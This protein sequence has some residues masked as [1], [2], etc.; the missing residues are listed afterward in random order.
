MKKIILSCI[1]ALCCV[2]A[3]AQD[4]QGSGFTIDLDVIG[5]IDAVGEFP[6][7]TGAKPSYNSG[8]SVVYTK[9]ESSFAE[10]FNL[11]WAAHWANTGGEQ[12]PFYSTPDLYRNTLLTDCTDWTDIF[13]IDFTMQGFNFRLGKDCLALGGFDYE[14]WDWDV[15]FATASSFWLNNASYQWGAQVGYTTP[16]ES[17]NFTFQVQS[18]PFTYMSCSD[19]QTQYPWVNGIGTY[20]LKYTGEYGPIYTSNSYNFI[21]SNKWGSGVSKGLH[22][23]ALG[24]MGNFLDCASVGLEWASRSDEGSAFCSQTHQVDMLASWEINDFV[25]LEGKIGWEKIASAH[26]M[27][28]Y[29]A[30]PYDRLWG[31]ITANV[32]PIPGNK[33]LRVMATVAGSNTRVQG[34]AAKS[35][36]ATLGIIYNHTFH[37]KK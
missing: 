19:A 35:M 17:S 34:F 30:V 9:L 25:S 36:S 8:N 33:D 24:V 2:S 15:D 27:D 28:F 12:I 3:F 1:A 18:S 21:Q 31:G 16:D 37:L 29:G 20:S 7:G 26:E 23:L 4:E 6:L 11:V 14:A 13:Y 10:Y 5:R 32:F 22:I